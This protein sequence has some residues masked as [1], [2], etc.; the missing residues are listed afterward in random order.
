MA[1]R[2][3]R[4]A[5]RGPSSPD[6]GQERPNDRLRPGAVVDLGIRDDALDSRPSSRPPVRPATNR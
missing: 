5:I 4:L 6:L 2:K 3:G 1:V